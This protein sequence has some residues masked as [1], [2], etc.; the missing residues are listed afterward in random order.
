M[1]VEDGGMEKGTECQ[2]DRWGTSKLIKDRGVGESA[3]P[4]GM[5]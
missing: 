2:T 4:D 3:F 1:S 5:F